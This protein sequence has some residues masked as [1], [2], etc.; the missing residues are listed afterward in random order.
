MNQ[1]VSTGSGERPGPQIMLPE[2]SRAPSSPE[3]LLAA[4]IVIQEMEVTRRI[5]ARREWMEAVILLARARLEQEFGPLPTGELQGSVN[6]SMDD[7][8]D[9]ATVLF[10]ETFGSPD[11]ETSVERDLRYQLSNGILKVESKNRITTS[12]QPK[13]YERLTRTLNLRLV[14][15]EGVWTAIPNR[16]NGGENRNNVAIWERVSS[17]HLSSVYPQ[18]EGHGLTLKANMGDYGYSLGGN[19][20]ERGLQFRDL[21]DALHPDSGFWESKDGARVTELFGVERELLEGF[22]NTRFPDLLNHMWKAAEPP[23]I[24]TSR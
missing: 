3:A 24:S 8:I 5:E 22:D 9:K 7:G 10:R 12:Q 20:D 14:E 17:V 21:T 6:G 19:I 16:T 2:T 4:A 18:V 13:N 15:E 11:E 1:V 23:A